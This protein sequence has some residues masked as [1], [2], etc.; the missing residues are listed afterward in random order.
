MFCFETRLKK[1]YLIKLKLAN[2]STFPMSSLEIT[3]LIGCPLACTFCPQDSL[4]KSYGTGNQRLLTLDKFKQIIT[5]L[6][7]HVRIDFSG[8]AEPFVNPECIEMVRFA[9]T[10]LNPIAIYT[11]LQGLNESGAIILKELIKYGRVSIFVIHLPDDTGNMR[12]FHLTDEYMK[13]LEILLPLDSVD[14]MTMSIDAKVDPQLLTLISSSSIKSK[15]LNKL[16]KT[17]FKGIRRAGSLNTKNLSP[18]SLHQEVQWKCAISC[19]STPFYDHN[20]LL[21]DGTVVLCCMDYGLK[22]KLG[23]LL[24]QD[25]KSLFL[26]DEIKRVQSLN[27]LIDAKEKSESICTSCENTCTYVSSNGSW[28]ASAYPFAMTSTKHILLEIKARILK[29]L[30][31]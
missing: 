20:V 18:D 27:M 21:P 16:P 31:F 6:P 4:A 11:T 3:T 14:C 29:K 26:G 23:N 7:P 22:H 1:A 8:M 13:C 9:A 10:T 12:G 30:N 2:S 15:L 25:Y 24:D 5:K 17:S 28:L 19:K